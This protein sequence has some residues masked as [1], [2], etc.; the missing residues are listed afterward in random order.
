MTLIRLISVPAEP[1]PVEIVL[2]LYFCVFL[3]FSSFLLLL[4]FFGGGVYYLS[5][6]GN[7]L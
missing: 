3:F 4:F 7:S 1:E 2:F 5:V 6:T